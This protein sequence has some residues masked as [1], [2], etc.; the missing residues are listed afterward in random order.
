MEQLPT[1][2]PNTPETPIAEEHSGVEILRLSRRSFLQGNIAAALGLAAGLSPAEADEH[3]KGAEAKH[4]GPETRSD[5]PTTLMTAMGFYL[6]TE[7]YKHF[8]VIPGVKK[9]HQFEIPVKA[10]TQ[11]IDR[12]ASGTFFE[13]KVGKLRHEIRLDSR[14]VPEYP[15]WVNRPV[16]SVREIPQTK[17]DIPYAGPGLPKEVVEK[18]PYQAQI[19]FLGTKV[20]AP[21]SKEGYAN[22]HTGKLSEKRLQIVYDPKLKKILLQSP[23]NA[24]L[25]PTF[26]EGKERLFVQFGY[27]ETTY[28]LETL[29]PDDWKSAEFKDTLHRPGVD[30]NIRLVERKLPSMVSEDGQTLQRLPEAFLKAHFLL[31]KPHKNDEDATVSVINGTEMQTEGEPG[32]T[33]LVHP[34]ER[35]IGGK[36]FLMGHNTPTLHLVPAFYRRWPKESLQSHEKPRLLIWESKGRLIFGYGVVSPQY[37]TA[38]VVPESAI[39]KALGFIFRIHDNYDTASLFPP[40]PRTRITY[41]SG[42]TQFQV[43]GFVI[44][45]K[46]FLEVKGRLPYEKTTYAPYHQADEALVSDAIVKIRTAAGDVPAR[47]TR[48]HEGHYVVRFA[49][50]P[51]GRHSAFKA[52]LYYKTTPDNKIDPKPLA[53]AGFQ[54]QVGQNLISHLIW[55]VSTGAGSKGKTPPIRLHTDDEG[56]PHSFIFTINGKEKILKIKAGGPDNNL[57]IPDIEELNLETIK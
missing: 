49:A 48:N 57:E 4:K 29:T 26:T 37:Q 17:E 33:V 1:P 28:E 53:Y 50:G 2:Q 32:E 5:R 56:L 24:Q 8:L 6:R 12:D 38:D 52:Y 42:S 30:E 46:R 51:I 31:V 3:K 27:E 54:K 16:W 41:P 21:I 15:K 35:F 47:L 11:F 43:T 45:N 23:K 19:D 44:D 7:R 36:D 39:Q 55:P 34:S 20:I 40:P 18:F 13:V 9:G 22:L 25:I 10:P 14:E